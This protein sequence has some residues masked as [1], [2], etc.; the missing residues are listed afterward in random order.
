[1][2]KQIALGQSMKTCLRCGKDKPET[3]FH[4]SGGGRRRPSCAPCR[5]ESRIGTR[6]G[7]RQETPEGR[8]RRLLWEEYKITL[9]QYLAILDAQG[10]ACAMCG[11]S[12]APGKWLAVDH[13]HTTGAV[14]AL[15]CTY[16][17]VIV[18]IYETHRQAAATY[19]A[20]YGTGNPLLKQ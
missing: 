20:T 9:E 17:N 15:L 7:E 5:S 14:R 16:C 18:G 3:A 4:K 2:M 6:I 1:M 12:P 10:G 8:R 13:C 19:L 11:K